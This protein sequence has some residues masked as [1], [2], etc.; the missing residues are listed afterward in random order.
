M[1]SKDLIHRPSLL[2]LSLDP[3]FHESSLL[4]FDSCRDTNIKHNENVKLIGSEDPPKDILI[5][6]IIT[7]K[8]NTFKLDN[9]IFGALTHI[10]SWT[11]KF[12]MIRNQSIQ[13]FIFLN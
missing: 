6:N 8:G 5:H 7:N 1:S 13:L 10:L 3:L 2:I 4:L 12:S 11:T 9:D